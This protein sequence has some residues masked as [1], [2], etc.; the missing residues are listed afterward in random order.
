MDQP[1]SHYMGIES[2]TSMA[3]PVVSAKVACMLAATPEL[4]LGQVLLQLQQQV[5][6]LGAP[7]K[8]QQFGYGVVT[9]P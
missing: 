7:G 5:I 3:T 2:G 4:L 1:L 8:D 6:D 9:R